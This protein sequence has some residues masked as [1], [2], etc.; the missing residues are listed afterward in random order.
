M[1]TLTRLSLASMLLKT[2]LPLE[3]G[4]LG[5]GRDNAAP[6]CYVTRRAEKCG[7][8]A[9]PQRRISGLTRISAS[10]RAFCLPSLR[11]RR[12]ERSLQMPI[13]STAC[14]GL[15]AKVGVTRP[16]TED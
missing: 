8:S 11:E 6:P 4:S 16:G 2:R 15:S 7:S 5:D 1:H 14:A 9:C 3:N 12:P 10:N 13:N